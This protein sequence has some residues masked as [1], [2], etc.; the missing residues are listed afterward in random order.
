MGQTSYVHAH[1]RDAIAGSCRRPLKGGRSPPPSE[2]QQRL[3]LGI[4]L[5]LRLLGLAL[6]EQIIQELS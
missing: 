2:G 6:G 1:A 3:Q 4:Q 5:W